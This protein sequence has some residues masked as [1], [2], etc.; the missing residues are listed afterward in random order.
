MTKKVSDSQDHG[1]VGE[2]EFRS[3]AAKMGWYPTKFDPDHGIDFVCQ[4]RGDRAGKTSSEMPGKTLNVSVRS[5]TDDSDTVVID[6]S[7]AELIFATSGPMVL[8]IVKRAPLQEAGQVAIKFVDEQFIR[9]LDAFLQGTAHT[10][11]V[12]FSEA[13]TDTG[14]IQ[15]NVDRLFRQSYADTIA[16]LR[17]ELRLKSLMA[18]PHVG[19]L[20]TKFG[21]FALVHSRDLSAQAEICQ[22]ANLAEVLKPIN[23]TPQF[24]AS[25][26]VFDRFGAMGTSGVESAR[27]ADDSSSLSQQGD[28]GQMVPSATEAPDREK[29]EQRIEALSFMQSIQNEL[30]LWNYNAA[31]L[32]AEKAEVVLKNTD[33]IAP[34]G[35]P[36]LLF[37]LARVH[38]IRAE[39]KDSQT[40]THI[41]RAKALLNQIESTAI[42]GDT[43]ELQADIEALRASIENLERG[44]DA[45][46]ARLSLC[47][48]P[49]AIRIRMAMLLN[50]QDL[51][52]AVAL[53]KGLSPHLYWCDLATTVYALKDRRSD[54]EKLLDWADAQQ[55]RSKYPQCVV[56][57]AD[58]LLARSLAGQQEGKN[59][60]PHDL[61]N[62]ERDN[63]REILDVLS[64]VLD[65]IVS[66]GHVD[67]ELCVAAVK[68]A[69]QANH[70]LG[71][72]KTVGELA[73][74][75]YTLHPV[76][77]DVAR[78]VV[79]GYIDP[80][81]DL[82]KRLR[83][84][85]PDNLDANILAAVVQSVCIQQYREAF[86]NAKKLVPLANTDEQKEE[87]FK[88]FQQLWQDL[89]GDD[90]SE[91]EQITEP[92]ISHNASLHAVFLAAKALRAGNPDDAIQVLDKHKAEDDI[93]WL[94]LRANA[95][96]Q[97]RQLGDA[98]EF[99]LIAAKKTREPT[100]LHKTA[101]MAFQAEKIDTSVW[102]YERLLEI[103]PG[104]MIARGNLA[105]LY[106]FYVHDVAKA[107]EQFQVLHDTEPEN[108]V[109]TINLAICLAQLYRPEQS[110]ALYNEACTQATPDIRAVL[111]RAEL[112]LSLAHAQESLSSL[113]EFREMFWHE[114]AFLLALMNSAY[115]AGDEEEAHEAF[116][117]LNKLREAGGVDP[118]AFR[119]IPAN[120]GLEMLKKGMKEAQERTEHLHAEMLK[121][122]MPW[123]WAEQVSNNAVYWGWRRRTQEMAWLGDDPMNRANFS[124]YAT[125]AFHA[126]R[127]ERGRCE[128]LPLDCPSEGTPVVADLSALI[129]LHRLELLDA[130]AGYFGEIIVPQAYLQT[131]L[132]DSRKI[133]LHQRSRQ[134]SAEQINKKAQ[135]GVIVVHAT[136]GQRDA[137]IALADEYA[138]TK[139]HRYHLIDVIRPIHQSG[140]ISD[141]AYEHISRVCAKKSGVDQEHPQLER[142]QDVL[143]ELSTLE[144]LAQFG[145]LDAV[146]TYYKI[147]ISADANTEIRQRLEAIEYQEESRRWHLD[148]WNH[149]RNDSRFRF[150]PHVIPETMKQ[151]D[152]DSKDYLSFISSFVAQKI[153]A[154]LLADDR[155]CQALTLNE[156]PDMPHSA[157]GSD[158]VVL[159]LAD[160]EKLSTLQATEA[161]RRLMS[162][163]YRFVLPP[164]RILKAL[165]QQYRANPPGQ[166]LQEAAEYVHDCMRD[167]GLLGGPE[168]T[169][170][171]DSMAIRL[172]LSW[173]SII[174]EFLVTVWDDESF[175]EQTASRLTKWSI[176]E[177][178]PSPPRVLHGS[179]KARI[180]SMTPRLLLSQALISS[181]M[182]FKG[183]RLSEAMKALKE[184]LKLRDDEYLQIVTDILND[185]RRTEQS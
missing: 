16:R 169:D 95:L 53:I 37:L 121:G 89:E 132:E 159:A 83:E 139:E 126:R 156:R 71:N 101:D 9:E 51:D 98:V 17:T 173:L 62:E 130:V 38:V 31:L 115:A 32:L 80:P 18:E 55:D 167:A 49:Y 163:R 61:S 145:M 107:A 176:Q 142:L 100:L 44:P 109:H 180:G 137:D 184:A 113:Q 136:R 36:S 134:H 28:T 181:S 69:W 74:L 39:R 120:E 165:A 23:A 87:L 46:L 50:K 151:K 125:N 147:H 127:S 72:R 170:L 26:F 148:L 34:A 149:I 7:D 110:L 140:A 162:W 144:T 24:T 57:L 117:A 104:N 179:M 153:E 111:G 118:N 152:A 182:L 15:Y 25:S 166:G 56:R 91:C 2:N 73:Q 124:I 129:T 6:R 160:A 146:T 81:P 128:L 27:V 5:T 76:P 58:A 154:P 14:K 161:I 92:L 123:I 175:S 3:W 131:V 10:Y 30:S 135:N 102:C 157:F 42:E 178:V 48:T 41:T 68:I 67:S 112:H 35:M 185:T 43:T 94:Q 52:A 119:M 45:A 66:A 20:R 97:K 93:Y 82:P 143:V 4:I 168:K 103:Q 88:L 11:T 65:P 99:L 77:I 172:Y 79:S 70:L 64:P 22:K 60:Q 158:V 8:A 177:L 13:V 164:A 29:Q 150:I 155:V 114:P 133:L 86:V 47:T 174:A 105:T 138:D 19:I 122:R 96:M 108:P 54:A 183:S 21:T 85:H 1:Y 63:V 171:K 78:S 59:I 12:R 116:K 33:G 141:A 40:E 75:M 106:S 84:E 90:V